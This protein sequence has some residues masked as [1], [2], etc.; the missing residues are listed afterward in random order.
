[1]RTPRLLALFV[2]A[3]ACSA[4]PPAKPAVPAA[5][6]GQPLNKV[7]PVELVK[8]LDQP[9]KYDGQT[10]LTSGQVRAACTNKGCWM[11]LAPSMDKAA[12][13]CRVTFKDYGFFVPTTSAGKRARVEAKVAVKTISA[14]EVAHMEGEGATMKN[15]QPD[16]SAK[17]IRLIATGVELSDG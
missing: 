17:E 10:V 12:P 2:L 3:A 8:V 4:P 1:M 14:D 11:E 6:Y 15:K 16:G 7:A 5:S 9:E 13:G